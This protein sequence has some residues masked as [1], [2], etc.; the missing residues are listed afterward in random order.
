MTALTATPGRMDAPWTGAG[1]RRSPHLVS[2]PTG[3]AVS[4]R[5]REGLQITRR[6]RLAIT[7]ATL[8]VAGVA[9]ASL[10]LGG[11]AAAPQEVTVEPGQTLS[12]IAESELAGVST[13]SAVARIQAANGL[14]TS[15]VHAGQMLVIP[16]P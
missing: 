15:H 11:P 16:A 5:A 6:G 4:D 13:A 3:D 8:L 7:T 1:A 12:Q 9:G 10:A 2:V 14:P